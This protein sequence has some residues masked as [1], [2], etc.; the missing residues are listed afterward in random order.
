MS[1]AHRL[2]LHQVAGGKPLGSKERLRDHFSMTTRY[3]PS[4]HGRRA[5]PTLGYIQLGGV[6]GGKG[7]FTH[8]QNYV[9]FSPL[10][11]RGSSTLMGFMLRP[12]KFQ[13]VKITDPANAGRRLLKVNFADGSMKDRYSLVVCPEAAGPHRLIIRDGNNVTHVLPLRPYDQTKFYDTEPLLAQTPIA[14]QRAISEIRRLVKYNYYVDF[15]IESGTI[16]ELRLSG[17]HGTDQTLRQ[18]THLRHLKHLDLTSCRELTPAGLAPLRDLQNLES[19]SF[20]C[21]PISDDGLRHF[22]GLRGL[23]FLNL[24][25]GKITRN[26]MILGP[27]LTDAGLKHI[28]GLVNLESLT[29]SGQGI[30]DAGL[31]HLKGLTSL[32]VLSLL[33]TQVTLTGIIKLSEALPNT[34]I[35]AGWCRVRRKTGSLWLEG[36]GTSDFHLEQASALRGLKAL[37]IHNMGNITDAGLENLTRFEA[38]ERLT[39]QHGR[40]ITDAGLKHVGRLGKLRK[41]NLWYCRN[42]TDNGADHL[43]GLT[44]LQELELGATKVSARGI[45]V[46]QEALPDCKIRGNH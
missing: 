29:I 15:K 33:G 41:L 12:V 32:Q 10:T 14:E 13:E 25:S 31:A 23:K 36:S 7:T 19:L 17:G 9:R 16:V 21:T 8:D 2:P 24:D 18:L 44:S 45:D 46:L 34:D 3:F 20:Y 11:G 6:L 28:E 40:Q 5:E 39:M 26:G 42:I 22:A 30:T 4:V 38:L 37:N 43:K 27:R 35:R 1:L